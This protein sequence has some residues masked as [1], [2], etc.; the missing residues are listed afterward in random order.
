MNNRLVIKMR[1]G[2][3][4]LTLETIIPFNSRNETIVLK[5]TGQMLSWHAI[6]TFSGIELKVK[7]RK[8]KDKL[9]AAT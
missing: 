9:A 8:M 7:Y 1:I 5:Y 4:K 3:K 6:T 2:V